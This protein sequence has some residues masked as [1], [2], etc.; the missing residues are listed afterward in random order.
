MQEIRSMRNHIWRFFCCILP[1]WC[2]HCTACIW[3]KLF[4]LKIYFINKKLLVNCCIVVFIV[5]TAMNEEFFYYKFSEH[6][7]EDIHKCFLCSSIMSWCAMAKFFCAE[8]LRASY[9][10]SKGRKAYTWIPHHMLAVHVKAGHVWAVNTGSYNNSSHHI[11]S[12][13]KNMILSWLA[14]Q[15]HNCISLFASLYL[16]HR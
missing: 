6:A 5:S 12:P 4:V 14:V 15:P 16:F 8:C 9:K 10:I 3:F 13:H 7:S 1:V 11:T 2:R